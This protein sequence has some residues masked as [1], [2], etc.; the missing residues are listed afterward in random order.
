M[1][2]VNGRRSAPQGEAVT[3]GL[4]EGLG[5][6]L[7]VG[8]DETEGLLV[9][10]VVGPCSGL[11]PAN[12]A[13]APSVAASRLKIMR[14]S[15]WGSGDGPDRTEVSP[16]RVVVGDLPG[17]GAYGGCGRRP[18][19]CSSGRC[20]TTDGGTSPTEAICLVRRAGRR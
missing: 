17:L 13:S 12:T 5:L 9:G 16:S 4:G 20:S 10:A 19:K 18:T 6:G 14:A 2:N 3:V 11:Q 1:R 7:G 8:L 15:L